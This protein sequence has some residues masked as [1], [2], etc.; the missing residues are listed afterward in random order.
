MGPT[1]IISGQVVPGTVTSTMA[2]TV[3]GALIGAARVMGGTNAQINNHSN[4]GTNF[5]HCN[6]TEHSLAVQLILNGCCF[7]KFIIFL[8]RSL[9]FLPFTTTLTAINIS[10]KG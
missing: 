7:H 10:Y 9:Y 3:V 2:P 8:L 1:F 5:S 4:S 6:I